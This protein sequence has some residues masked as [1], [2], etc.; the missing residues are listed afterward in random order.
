MVKLYSFLLLF[1]PC[2]MVACYRHFPV[3]NI[4]LK[5]T[6]NTEIKCIQNYSE[7]VR[8]MLKF[9]ISR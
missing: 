3:K 4:K 7:Y 1:S 2:K 5:Y 6:F 9:L 8:Y